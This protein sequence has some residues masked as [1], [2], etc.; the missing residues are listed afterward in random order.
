M[1]RNEHEKAREMIALSGGQTPSGDQQSWL[2][3]HL[4]ECASC[5]D[6]ADAVGRTVSALR[7]EPQAADFAL[8][9]T[10]RKRVRLRAVELRQRQE[11]IW[12]CCLA[13]V[14]VG[15][16]TAI[17]TPLFWAVC[18]WIGQ[19]A[20]VANWV[21][22]SGF[23]FFWIVPALVVSALLMA[24]GTHSTNDEKYEL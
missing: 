18:E 5:T 7:S 16:S 14:F 11:R 17:T 2:R 24:H 13:C 19:R 8:V 23:G 3:D 10:T 6:F 22:Q 21:W 4:R 12:L 1:N 20:G 15:L 9:E